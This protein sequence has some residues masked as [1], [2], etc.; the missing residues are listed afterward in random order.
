[1]PNRILKE[2]ICSS[3][4]VDA[5]TWFQECL[6]TR[7]ITACDD[8]GRCDAR[9][10]LLK[11][12]L[13]PL[14]DDVTARQV[15]EALECLRALGCIALYE[16]GGRPYLYM[17]GW[18]R[19]QCIRAKRS[20]YP[21]PEEEGGTSDGVCGQMHADAPEIQSVSETESGSGARSGNGG[22]ALPPAE[23]KRPRGRYGRVRLTDR[24]WEQL[25]A[26]LGREEAERCLTLVDEKAELTGNR[27]GWQN[28]DLLVRR[29][30]R[31]KWGFRPGDRAEPP[32]K[33]W[34]APTAAELERMKKTLAEIGGEA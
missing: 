16:S 32:E 13:F 2:S 22:A 17:T 15:A 21:A 29:C 12:R 4:T 9:P 18:N 30:F 3:D 33:T 25:C 11:S 23:E 20:K 10:A 5:M 31:E 1:M 27:N 14:K 24:Q 34:S 8:Y 7:L 26:D 6:F 28:W 19:H